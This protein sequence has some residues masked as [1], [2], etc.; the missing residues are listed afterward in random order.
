MPRLG[1]VDQV[2]LTL[3]AVALGVVAGRL[4]PPRAARFARPTLRVPW[5]LMTG[6]ALE[7]AGARTHGSIAFG[8]VMASSAMLIAFACANL[9]LTGMGV[10]AIGVGANVLVILVNGAMPVRADALAG[11]H[12]VARDQLDRVELD[13]ARHLESGG[14]HLVVL[15]D[16]IPVPAVHQVVS[17]GDLVIFVSTADVVANLVRRQARRRRHSASPEPAITS[18]SPAQDCGVAPRPV[19]SSGSQN[20]DNPDAIAPRTVAAATGAPASHS[21]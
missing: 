9:H 1:T 17:F 19:P 16:I 8:L 4:A 11:A 6:V 20:S 12:V 10:L 21:R 18:A 14:D 13:G 2:L 5:V 3:V 15:A 7:V